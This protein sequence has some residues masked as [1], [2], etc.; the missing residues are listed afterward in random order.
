MDCTVERICMNILK[1]S[2]REL[3]MNSSNFSIDIPII[4]LLRLEHSRASDI[5]ANNREITKLEKSIKILHRKERKV[6]NRL[7]RF[8]PHTSKYKNLTRLRKTLPIHTRKRILVDKKRDP[9]CIHIYPIAISKCS[10]RERWRV[11]RN[12]SRSSLKWRLYEL[13]DLM[14]WNGSYMAMLIVFY[15]LSIKREI[16]QMDYERTG[17]KLSN[18]W[19]RSSKE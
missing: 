6:S 5:S 8:F 17:G 9:L 1:E 11:W 13:Y 10:S 2:I 4:G 16:I 3:S 18:F 7:L 12:K 19:E 15:P 14:I